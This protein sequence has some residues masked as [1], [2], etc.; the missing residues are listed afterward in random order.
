MTQPAEIMVVTPHA[1]DAEFGVA[2]TVGHWTKEGRNVIYVV[3][4]N[5]DKGTSNRNMN[6]EDLVKIR[7][8]EQKAAA[9]LLGVRQVIFLGYPDQSLED[10]PD[11]R[12]ELVR[13]IR[14]Y[15]PET[16]VTADP[17]LGPYDVEIVW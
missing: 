11:F 6:P 3:C 17:Q 4:T 14:T 1:D 13:L 15:Q 9:R 2:G 7:E 12:K 5:G 16:V 10:T 8:K